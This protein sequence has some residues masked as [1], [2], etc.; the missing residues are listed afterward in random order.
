MT[1]V[2]ALRPRPDRSFERFYRR[3]AGDLYRFALALAGD[4]HDAETITQDAFASAYR[5]LREGD[6][7]GRAESWL[8]GLVLDICRDREEPRTVPAEAGGDD[9]TDDGSLECREAELAISRVLDGLLARREQE[10]LRIHLAWCGDCAA[11]ARDQ[12]AHRPALEV[13]A[14]V[15]LPPALAAWTTA[16]SAAVAGPM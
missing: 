9:E 4:P 13:L 3:H 8:A 5:A 14:R 7:P 1:S 11:F 10:A 16:D 2:A 6:R 12:R 15:P